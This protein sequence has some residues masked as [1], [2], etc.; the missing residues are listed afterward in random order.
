MNTFKNGV[1]SRI[2]TSMVLKAGICGPIPKRN[3]L[4]GGRITICGIMMSKP[5]A[6]KSPS[7]RTTI[8]MNRGHRTCGTILARN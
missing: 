7:L 6:I 1:T 8:V 2:R 5:G 4:S 3:L